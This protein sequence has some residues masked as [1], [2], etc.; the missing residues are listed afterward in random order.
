MRQC[1]AVAWEGWTTEAVRGDKLSMGRRT[2]LDG[3]LRG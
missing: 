3:P 2:L 1:P